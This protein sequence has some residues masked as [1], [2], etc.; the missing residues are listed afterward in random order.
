MKILASL[1][2]WVVLTDLGTLTWFD[3]GGVISSVV[4]FGESF[5]AIKIKT[6]NESCFSGNKWHVPQCPLVGDVFYC[7]KEV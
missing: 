6:G 7:F 5:M 3:K 2:W 1:L 4:A